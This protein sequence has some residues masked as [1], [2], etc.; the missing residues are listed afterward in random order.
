MQ[1]HLWL[2]A[3]ILDFF[4]SVNTVEN[5]VIYINTVSSTKASV[6]PLE[7]DASFQTHWS[8]QV[9]K[10][11]RKNWCSTDISAFQR[12]RKLNGY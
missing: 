7:T 6:S 9:A 11:S 2:Y 10:G 12:R 4:S 8:Q 3:V 5:N 1:E